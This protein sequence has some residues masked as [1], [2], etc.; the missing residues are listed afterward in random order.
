VR[1]LDRDLAEVA[2]IKAGEYEKTGVSQ[3][4]RVDD[5]EAI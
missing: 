3:R 1:G 5:L 4:P 2:D